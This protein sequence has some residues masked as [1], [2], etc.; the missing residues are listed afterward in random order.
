MSAS[1][2]GRKNSERPPIRPPIDSEADRLAGGAPYRAPPRKPIRHA[3]AARLAG[4]KRNT[5]PHYEL[6]PM[7]TAT[8][9]DVPPGRD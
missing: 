4:G 6:T 9:T 5:Q 8:P 7:A 2:G 1:I 3:T